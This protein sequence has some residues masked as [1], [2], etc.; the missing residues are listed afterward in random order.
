MSN[1]KVEQN[2][3][4]NQLLN[5]Q[6]ENRASDPTREAFLTRPLGSLI[7][8]NALPAVASMLFMA[9]YQIVDG[10]LVGRRLGP[11]ALASVNILYPILALFIGLAVMIGVGGNSRIAVLLGAGE[12]K[13]ARRV[14]GLVISLGTFLGV[15][16]SLITI[17]AFSGILTALGTSGALGELAGQY[18][19]GRA[20]WRERV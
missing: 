9:L 18:Q 3:L 14:L 5:Q 2:A 10:I 16:G 7:L 8:E 20:S 11:E 12:T 6:G 19:I 1:E 15:T 17:F 13:Q 4:A